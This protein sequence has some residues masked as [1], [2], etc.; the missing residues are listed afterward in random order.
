MLVITLQRECGLIG[1]F[2]KV[3]PLQYD[4]HAARTHWADFPS[5][6]FHHALTD[7][8]VR[9]VWIA[10]Y[11]QT[12]AA[13]QSC[14]TPAQPVIL[15][16]AAVYCFGQRSEAF[17]EALHWQSSHFA[18]LKR[19]LRLNIKLFINESISS[20][21]QKAPWMQ[22]SK[23]DVYENK[24]ITLEASLFEN[25][26]SLHCVFSLCE[27]QIELNLNSEFWGF[28]SEWASRG[29]REEW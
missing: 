8:S 26:P 3:H 25:T 20:S 15:L 22:L 24:I 5:W 27:G 2:L 1:Y 6:H 29:K 23:S 11:M 17:T 12:S 10:H 7:L 9:C 14:V 16:W 4:L 18:W 19:Q 13:Y 28:M 21:S